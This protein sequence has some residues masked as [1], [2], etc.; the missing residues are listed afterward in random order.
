MIQVLLIIHLIVAAALILLILLQKSEGG[1]AGAGMSATASVSTMMQPRARPNPLS[2]M[3]TWLGIGFFATSLGL[4]L[5]AKPETAPS[6]MFTPQ[7]DG[8]AVPSVENSV[9]VPN[10]T[11]PAAGESPA[12]P[13]AAP[14]VPNN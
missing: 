4:A 1:A 6:S 11:V 3:T 5:L 2:R 8:P 14:S 7:V 13:P 12:A 9:T 10:T